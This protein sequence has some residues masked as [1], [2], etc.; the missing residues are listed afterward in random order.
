MSNSLTVH[1]G[2]PTAYIPSNDPYFY[3]TGRIDYSN[4]KAIRFTYPGIS[5]NARFESAYCILHLKNKGF[6]KDADGNPTKNFYQIIVDGIP[7]EVI[8][9]HDGQSTQRIELGPGI[10]ELTIFKRTESSVGEGVFEGLEIEAGKK[11]LDW[12][13]K[14]KFKIEFI[15][16][17]ITC[18]YGNEG[19]T[20]ACKFSPETENNYLAY[21]AITARNLN[22][23]YVAV[24]YSGKGI[25]QN[26]DT[27]DKET[28]P[29]LYD[30]TIP[31][32][33]ENVWDIKRWQ[34]DVVVIN[35]G[36][37]DFAHDAPPMNEFVKVYVRFLKKIRTYYPQ[38]KIVCIEAPMTTDFWPVGIK[39]LTNVKKYI[40][41]AV[42]ESNDPNI[43]F[44]FPA[45]Q[46][47]E[48]FGCD[49]H[50]KVNRHKKMAEDLTGFIGNFL[51]N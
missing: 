29:V 16:N 25:Y 1:A 30:R 5:I 50:P 11:L 4:P 35:L 28:M 37:N 34:P 12:E 42:S 44:F 19:A 51:A 43:R 24:A 2:K 23:E 45:S 40:E 20:Q 41:A 18:G 31:F 13:S 21:G 14:T 9:I 46:L 47:A 22:A 48:D 7:K 36:T 26:Y 15:G 27:T 38:S 3:F 8:S 6:R 17:S 39:A 33:S 32:E 49:F 10:H